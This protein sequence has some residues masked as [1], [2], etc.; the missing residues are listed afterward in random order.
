MRNLGGL[1]EAESVAGGGRRFSQ[2]LGILFQGGKMWGRCWGHVFPWKIFFFS[3]FFFFFLLAEPCS[4]QELRSP[5]RDRT[6]TP[7]SGSAES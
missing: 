5:T 4:L 2:W 1:L 3:F 7:Y 6:C